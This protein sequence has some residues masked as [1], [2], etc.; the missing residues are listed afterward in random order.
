VNSPRPKTAAV[1]IRPSDLSQ[2]LGAG[3]GTRAVEVC[4]PLTADFLLIFH[5]VGN[6]GQVGVVPPIAGSEREEQGD[7]H[8]NTMIGW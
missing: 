3:F 1:L 4:I 7:W 6:D 8:T 5:N 2:R